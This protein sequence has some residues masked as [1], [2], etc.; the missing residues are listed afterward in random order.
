MPR[1]HAF[2]LGACFLS[3]W[4]GAAHAHEDPSSH[5]SNL[6]RLLSENPDDPDLYLQRGEFYRL[7]GNWSAAETDYLAAQ[8]SGADISRTAICFAALAMDRGNP[9]SALESL[10]LVSGINTQALFIEGRAL[11]QLGRHYEAAKFLEQ[12]VAQ[13]SRPRPEDYLELSEVILEQG[14]ASIPRALEVLDAGILRL[15]PLASLVLAA[16][17]LELRRGQFS[18]VLDRLDA[19]PP[20]LDKSPAWMT[21]K[22]EILMQAEFEMEAQ[23]TFTEALSL[24]RA[25]PSHRRS[26]LANISL[27]AKLLEYLSTSHQNSSG[28]DH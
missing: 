21:Q 23:A 20:V 26:A 24:L 4:F 16:T 18:S 15:G 17:T 22:G 14:D 11:H 5:I 28:D 25:Y 27:E 8:E 3:L 2:I 9:K 19:E 1:S 6:S 13:S 7:H 12:A 10:L